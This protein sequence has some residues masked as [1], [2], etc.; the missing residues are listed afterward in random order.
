MLGVVSEADELAKAADVYRSAYEALA[1]GRAD[2]AEK[3][4]EAAR[5]GVAQ[6]EIVRLSGY[7]REHVRRICRAAGLE[8]QGD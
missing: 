5:A 2:L 7:T 4:V 3:I 8:P 6:R 1:T